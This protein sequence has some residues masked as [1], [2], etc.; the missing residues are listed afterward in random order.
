MLRFRVIQRRAQRGNLRLKGV[1]GRV[2]FIARQFVQ[3]SPQ[4]ASFLPEM[5]EFGSARLGVGDVGG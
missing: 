1:G 2:V 3:L 5:V 4:R